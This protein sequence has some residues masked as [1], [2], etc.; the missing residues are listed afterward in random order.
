[1]NTDNSFIL[2]Q[3]IEP[4]FLYIYTVYTQKFGTG[5]FF[6]CFWRMSLMLIN[7]A[8]IWLKKPK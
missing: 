2:T 7:A 8:F 6:L 1:M 3:Y 5:N 4:I